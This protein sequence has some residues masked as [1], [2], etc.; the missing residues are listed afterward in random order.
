MGD[1]VKIDC[2]RWHVS[3]SLV[4]YGLAKI[5]V[6]VPLEEGDDPR[7]SLRIDV[8]SDFGNMTTDVELEE[9]INVYRL[10]W[11]NGKPTEAALE[12]SDTVRNVL[13]K[14]IVCK[15]KGEKR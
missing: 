10:F 6:Y 15:E 4:L 11:R 13:S 9:A 8:D 3:I 14:Y 12:L 2:R 5:V 7:G 1:Q